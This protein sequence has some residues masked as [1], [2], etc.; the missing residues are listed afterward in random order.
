MFSKLPVELGV[1]SLKCPWATKR[2]YFHLRRAE[3]IFQKVFR[4]KY[5]ECRMMSRIGF[6]LLCIC[7]S[8][9]QEFGVNFVSES[10]TRARGELISASLNKT[11]YNHPQA[12]T[13]VPLLF[14]EPSAHSLAFTESHMCPANP[15]SPQDLS[16]VQM[17]K[18]CPTHLAPG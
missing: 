13:C 6:L 12:V 17:L 5:R 10:M 3:L 11:N 2:S 14:S 1:H 4:A 15:T 16:F 8:F 7:F 18:R 9:L